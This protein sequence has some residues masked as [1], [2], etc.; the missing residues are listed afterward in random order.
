MNNDHNPPSNPSP[1]D[2]KNDP[3]NK[4]DA[5]MPGAELSIEQRALAALAEERERHADVCRALQ[6]KIRS[7]NAALEKNEREAREQGHEDSS[8]IRHL[9]EKLSDE[10]AETKTTISTLCDESESR[11]RWV[12]LVWLLLAITLGLL[13]GVWSRRS[14]E[15]QARDRENRQSWNGPS[16][17]GVP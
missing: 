13:I 5:N 2:G 8:T 7:Q 9:R 11:R 4:Q 12:I 6:E 17:G 14:E 10:R 3:S 1:D 16:A 15:R